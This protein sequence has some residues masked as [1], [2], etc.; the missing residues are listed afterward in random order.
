MVRCLS[1]QAVVGLCIICV[2]TCRAGTLQ[3][4]AKAGDLTAIAQELAAG[5]I[6]GQLDGAGDPALVL[7]ALK[8]HDRAVELLLDRGAD[9]SV[10]NRSGLT[11]LHAAAYGGSLEVVKLLVARGASVND[12]AN[13]YHM[14]PLLA[15]AEE[16]HTGVVAFLLDNKADIDAKE[17]NG[18]TSLTQAGWRGYWSVGEMLIKAGA[19]CQGADV[20]GARLSTECIAHAK[21]A[22]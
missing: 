2:G 19:I 20:V 21:T 9:I 12:V 4:A 5:A 10:R 17:R 14:S 7:A 6:I 11:A 16:G 8:G 22:H 18:Y 1:V 15:A 3:E 13:F